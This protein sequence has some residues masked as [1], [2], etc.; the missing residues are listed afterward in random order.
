MFLERALELVSRNALAALVVSESWLFNSAYEAMRRQVAR[1][2]RLRV[3]ACIDK[4]AF[5]VRLNT[6]A[7]VMERDGDRGDSIFF[8]VDAELIQ[9]DQL[10][11][12]PPRDQP[13][14]R[15]DLDSLGQVP[16]GAFVFDMPGPLLALYKAHPTVGDVIDVKQGLATAD[17]GRFVRFWWETSR[18]S[19]A[20]D[21]VDRAQAKQIRARW[22]PYNKG[23]T[24]IPWWGNQDHVVNWEDD[25]FEI[26]SFGTEDGGK[27]RSAV[28]NPDFYFKSAISWSNIGSGGAR[29][30]LVPHGFIFD[31]AGMSAFPPNATQQLALLGYLNCTLVRK[32]LDVI[33]P[34]LNYQVGDVQ[35]LP[36]L[37]SRQTNG[38][39]VARLVELTREAWKEHE[40]AH[41]F[42][43]DIWVVPPSGSLEDRN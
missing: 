10:S 21:C 43:G 1:E 2:A 31:V 16:G 11:A 29:F 37:T 24:P 9:T 17:N 40:T 33:A 6:A 42:D 20:F 36:L 30:R 8:R 4:A 18:G 5:G 27:P 41:G 28:R 7:S 25:G 32:G 14:Y 23:G 19:I 12:L 26:R 3:T 38:E 15:V 34:T 22:F 39:C 35:R 13:V